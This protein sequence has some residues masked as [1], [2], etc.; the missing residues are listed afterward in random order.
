MPLERG[1]RLG[2]YQIDAFIGDGG[3]RLKNR[4]MSSLFPMALAITGVL[5][6]QTPMAAQTQTMAS[7]TPPPPSTPWG[8]PD[9]GGI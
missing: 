6:A 2:P 5:L 7:E 1:A 8:A 4:Y 3:V 9:L